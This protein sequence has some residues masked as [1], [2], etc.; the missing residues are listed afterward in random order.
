MTFNEFKT[1]WENEILP[2]KLDFI[3]SGQSLVN[4]LSEVWFEEYKRLVY[5]DRID[6][7]YVDSRIPMTLEYLES[8]W[9]TYPN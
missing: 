4:Y 8:V 7:F 5:Q 2:N 3:R 9:N 6:C 1:T